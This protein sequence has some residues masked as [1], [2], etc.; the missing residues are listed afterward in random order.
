MEGIQANNLEHLNYVSGTVR[1]CVLCC[2]AEDT[3]SLDGTDTSFC[4]G[5][6]L[7]AALNVFAYYSKCIY[8]AEEQLYGFLRCLGW[9]TS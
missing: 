8:I 7:K 1:S 9:I 6:L 3:W 4:D 2:V 5:S